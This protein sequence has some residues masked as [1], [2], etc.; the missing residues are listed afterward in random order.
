MARGTAKRNECSEAGSQKGGARQVDDPA[1]RPKRGQRRHRDKKSG[2]A[3]KPIELYYW[4]TPNG[5]KISIMLEE[6]RCPT[7]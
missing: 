6:C 4:A 5:F 2:S 3:A 7:P 1:R